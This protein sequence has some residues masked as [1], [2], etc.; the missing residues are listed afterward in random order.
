MFCKEPNSKYLSIY[1]PLGFCCSDRALAHKAATDH[2]T[3]WCGPAPIKCYFQ[4]QPVSL[5][6]PLGHS[7]RPQFEVIRTP[8]LKAMLLKYSSHCM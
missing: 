5:I 1:R 6:W 8:I 2:V 7:A 3:G 4:K